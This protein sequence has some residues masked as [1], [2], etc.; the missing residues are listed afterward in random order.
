[1]NDDGQSG[2][3]DRTILRQRHPNLRHRHPPVRQCQK[4]FF[5]HR[6]LDKTIGDAF[7]CLDRKKWQKSWLIPAGTGFDP[8]NLQVVDFQMFT[9]SGIQDL[10]AF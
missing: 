3:L 5:I 4:P 7:L 1:V 2:R 9:V 8:L 6:Q 10:M